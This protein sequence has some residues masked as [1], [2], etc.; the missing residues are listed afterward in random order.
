[1][2][3]EDHFE[4]RHWESLRTEFL[5]IGCRQILE[6]E[7]RLGDI[8]FDRIRLKPEPADTETEFVDESHFPAGGFAGL[9]NRGSF[10]N[11]VLSELVYMS[12]EEEVSLF[13]LRYVEGELMFYLRD[14]GLL[15]RRRRT[16]HLIIDLGEFFHLR[17]PGYDYQFAILVQ[18]IILRLVRDLT[19][20]FSND[21]VQL[22]IHYLYRSNREPVEQEMQLLVLLLD[23][24]VQH[25]NVVF[26]LSEACELDELERRKRKPYA[27]IFAA[28]TADDWIEQLQAASEQN[29][30]GLVVSVAAEQ[31]GS[32]DLPL[33]GLEFE[34]IVQ[35]RDNI[36][37]ELVG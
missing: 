30:T 13:D 37:Q 14:E 17:S 4:L 7:G 16:I 8:D 1:M 29:L 12:T 18:G 11:M 24:E 15:R 3:A 2:G 21:A 5:R 25:G 26:H 9:T 10:E 35:L 31:T 6:L 36:V 33:D 27:V 19:A 23:D 32:L 28:E 22:E 20:V 34:Q